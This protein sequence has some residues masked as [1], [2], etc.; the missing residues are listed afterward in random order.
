[1]GVKINNTRFSFFKILTIAASSSFSQFLSKSECRQMIYVFSIASYMEEKTRKLL[2]QSHA[3]RK[4]K[5][6]ERKKKEHN[7]ELVIADGKNI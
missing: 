6:N 2:L 4:E 7:S 1:M 5:R 3:F